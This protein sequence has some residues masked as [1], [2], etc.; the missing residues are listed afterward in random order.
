MKS[1]S[2]HFE[3]KDFKLAFST[4]ENL[5]KE[6][7][8]NL[9]LVISTHDYTSGYWVE[10][11]DKKLSNSDFMYHGEEV[12]KLKERVMLATDNGLNV[13]RTGLIL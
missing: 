1:F 8:E 3:F 7:Y 11:T 9:R 12:F 4:Y 2:R 13:S 5:I 6:G 10:T